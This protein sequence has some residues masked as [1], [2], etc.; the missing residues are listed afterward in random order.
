MS[1]QAGKFISQWGY[2]G[3]RDA[4]EAAIDLEII[5]AWR[6]AG[7]LSYCSKPGHDVIQEIINTDGQK[8]D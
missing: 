7:Y 1:E 2:D 6:R 5:A 3:D 8:D 4:T